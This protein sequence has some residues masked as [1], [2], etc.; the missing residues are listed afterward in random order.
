MKKKKRFLFFVL[1]VAVV[2]LFGNA[3]KARALVLVPDDVVEPTTWTKANSPYIVQNFI[4]IKAPLVIEAG[5]VVKIQNFESD[6]RP[7]RPGLGIESAFTAVGEPLE[8]I[9]FTTV[10]DSNYGGDTHQYCSSADSVGRGSW[11]G[12]RVRVGFGQPVLIEYAKI[13]F[14]SNGINYDNNQ[15]NVTFKD[16]S[17]KHTEISFSFFAGIF[18]RCT[19]PKMENLTLTNNRNGIEV[20]NSVYEFMPKIRSSTIRDNQNAG[21]NNKPPAFLDARYNYWGYSSGPYYDY[22][23]QGGFEDANKSGLGNHIVGDFVL[24][25]PWDQSDPTIPKEPVIFIPGIGAS[26]NPDLMISGILADNWTMFDHT[27]DGILKA[28]RVMGYQEGK[29]F[30]IAYYDWRKGNDESAEKYLKPVI[31]KA[32]ALNDVTKVNLVT[33]SMGSLVA[34]S[35]VQ[36]P[37]YANNVDKLIMIAPPNRGSSDVYTLWEGGYVPKSWNNGWMMNA[38][39]NYLKLVKID[40]SAY[41]IIHKY[42]PALKDLMPVY[43]FLFPAGKADELKSF[44]EMLEQNTFLLDLNENVADLKA[45]TDF[46]IILGDKQPT[47]S[48]I[49]FVTS[50]QPG[51]W[52]D[53]KPS[54]LDPV[55]DDVSGD[56]E[57]LRFSGDIPSDFWAVLEYNHGE[58]VSKSEKIVADLLDE[59]LDYTF[60]SPKIEDELIIWTD[61]PGVLEVTDPTGAVAPKDNREETDVRYAQESGRSGFKIMS[62]PN[63]KKGQYNVA[64]KGSENGSYHLTTEYVNHKNESQQ[65]ETQEVQV[66]KDQTQNFVATIDPQNTETPIQEVQLQDEIAPIVVL[67]SPENDKTYTNDQI[68]PIVFSVSDNVSTNEKIVIE[69]YLDDDNKMFEGDSIDFS[70]LTLGQHYF[71]IN[72]IDE[73]GNYGYAEALFEVKKVEVPIDPPADSGNGSDD[74]GQDLSGGN[75]DSGGGNQDDGNSDPGSGSNPDQNPNPDQNSGSQP[76]VEVAATPAQPEEIVQEN[77][78]SNQKKSASHKKKK[79]VKIISITKFIEGV[80]VT[81]SNEP[82]KVLFSSGFNLS[83]RVEDEQNSFYQNLEEK[84]KGQLLALNENPI[85]DEE[86]IGNFQWQQRNSFFAMFAKA[87]KSP[88]KFLGGPTVLGAARADQQ[89]D[90][91]FNELNATQ[92]KAEKNR[93]VLLLEFFLALTATIF[94]ALSFPRTR[95]K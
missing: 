59:T 69:K 34:R 76:V 23:N 48:N 80:G 84:L 63:V 29:N 52:L 70:A 25:R 15:C 85:Q 7:T 92:K 28:F 47:V 62:V 40:F 72:A 39:I 91:N 90:V 31:Q 20:L 26:I 58:I 36:S 71:W 12:L 4:T 35:Y 22:F 6:D 67:Q 56:G 57:V 14:A 49:P 77:P 42:I 93:L 88:F 78:G 51:L 87:D 21:V 61:A 30:F 60:D 54:P 94:F 86:F 55:R 53:G 95:L 41:E 32:L 24:F 11:D 18:L 81:K 74:G 19:Q 45:K 3:S 2:W 82:I 79:Q 44:S 27:Y 66:Q 83:G 68:L 33:H 75:G 50:D 65:E 64:L 10:C 43:D 5:T 17:V 46:S 73:A 13:L 8:K 9:V 1:I 89:A 37:S 16:L 38:Y